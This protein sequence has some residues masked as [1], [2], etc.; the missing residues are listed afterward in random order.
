MLSGEGMV[1]RWIP[2]GRHS[3]DESDIKAVSEV[4]KSD[5]LTTGPRVG[6]FESL[7]AS[8]CDVRHGVAVSSGTA[9]L[10]CCMF[11]LGVG[12]GDEVVVPPIT[13]V[14][15]ANC[16][17]YQGGTPVFADVEPGT[18]L[19]DPDAVEAAITPRTKAIVGVD[20]AGQTCDWD[21]LRRIADRHGVALVADSCHALG[22]AY[23]GRKVGSLADMTVLS[24]HPVKH[25]AT[26]EGGM[27]LTDDEELARKVRLFRGHGI[28]SDAFS[29]EKEGAWF[30][31]MTDL[32]FN[33]R[34]TDIQC[35]LGISQLGRLDAF[36]ARRREI[37]S[38]YDAFF[39]G[40]CVTPLV[41]KEQRLHAYHLYVV[42]VPDRDR[43]FSDLRQA[44]IGV[45]VH[46]IPVH[47]HPYYR[48]RFNTGE[49][50]C[51]VAEKAYGR[52]L[53]LPMYPSMS[54]DDVAR[55]KATVLEVVER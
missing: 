19:L 18:L 16:V 53:S 44:Q 3:I 27:V 38:E 5:Y 21:A 55:T 42:E 47:F 40:T 15:S 14:A 39:R 49:G 36:L 30:Y 4:L 26:G 2:Y 6:E 20:Y 13:F 8:R 41:C 52:I 29:R 43:V 34:I 50:L 33:Y 12:P 17:V 31:E 11:A 22:G 46:Y 25:I 35:A 24:F 23:K 51:P 1:M 32:G 28:T 37:A 48:Q 7:V 9:A 54:D 10:H 45:N